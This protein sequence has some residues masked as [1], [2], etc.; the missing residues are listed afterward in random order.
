MTEIQIARRAVQLYAEQH[1]RPPHVTII[2]AAEML[3]LSRHTVSK[4]VKTGQIKLN[5]CGLIP[6]EQVDAA[7]Q[8]V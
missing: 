3:G 5:K 8:P 7:L 6:I 4:M 2:Q 1:P